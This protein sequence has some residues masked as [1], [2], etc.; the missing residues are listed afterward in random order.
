MVFIYFAKIFFLSNI[1]TTV[2]RVNRKREIVWPL[3]S[4][5]R[6]HVAIIWD[7]I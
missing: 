1:Y 3:N 7:I 2:F 5:N 4:E 6:G